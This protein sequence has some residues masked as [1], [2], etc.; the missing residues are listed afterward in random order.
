ME[1]ERELQGEDISSLDAKVFKWHVA[2]IKQTRYSGILQLNSKRE[3][4]ESHYARDIYR[5]NYR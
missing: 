3:R 5:F 1:R 2:T 4:L